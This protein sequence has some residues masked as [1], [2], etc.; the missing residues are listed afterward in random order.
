M[1]PAAFVS[2]RLQFALVS[3]GGFWRTV[4]PDGAV[5]LARTDEINLLTTEL[6]EFRRVPFEDTDTVVERLNSEITTFNA[7]FLILSIL[8]DETGFSTKLFSMQVVDDLLASGFDQHELLNILLSSPLPS[9]VRAARSSIRAFTTSFDS[10]NAVIRT[11]FESQESIDQVY[12]SWNQAK[13]EIDE[14]ESRQLETDLRIDGTFALL[15][16]AAQVSTVIEFNTMILDLLIAFP[17]NSNVRRIIEAIRVSLQRSLFGH[18]IKQ[19][20]LR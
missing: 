18:R 13:A 9:Q 6:A 17:N 5:E 7:L 15:V 10:L 14:A 19:K 11:L 2:G 20:C 3:S 1:T 4:T 12:A 8:S 16:R